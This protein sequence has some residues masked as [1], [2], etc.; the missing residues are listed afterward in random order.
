VIHPDSKIHIGQP[1]RHVLLTRFNARF[2]AKWTEL[3]LD[4]A[5]LG[6]RFS[7]FERFC[8]PSVQAQ[9][10]TGFTWLVFFHEGTPAY[11]AARGGVPRDETGL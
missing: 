5:W 8:Y 2:A 11:R 7:L 1:F 4:P 6:H 9:T 3:C 10:S